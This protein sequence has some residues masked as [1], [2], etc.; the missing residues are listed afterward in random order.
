LEYASLTESTP[1]VP[2]RDSMVIKTG[3]KI[4]EV[5]SNTPE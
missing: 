1:Q 5:T 2:K 4:E 3:P